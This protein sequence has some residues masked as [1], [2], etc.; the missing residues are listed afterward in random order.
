MDCPGEGQR[1]RLDGALWVFGKDRSGGSGHATWRSV[2]GIQWE[3]VETGA[4]VFS[5]A[6][7]VVHQDSLFLY[8]QSGEQ[9][10]PMRRYGAARA[11]VDSLQGIRYVLDQSPGTMPD[12]APLDPKTYVISEPLPPG[13]YWLHV[14][15][16]DSLGHL[17]AVAHRA[18]HVLPV[19][20]PTVAIDGSTSFS[21]IP[22][23]AMNISLVNQER[24]PEATDY[25]GLHSAP[26]GDADTAVSNSD[27]TLPCVAEGTYWLVAQSVDMYGI[28]SERFEQ[29][30]S[31][32]PPATLS[33]PTMHFAGLDPETEDKVH[34]YAP[35]GRDIWMSPARLGGDIA[36]TV[37]DHR[38]GLPT[39]FSEAT[40][41]PATGFPLPL[42]EVGRHY[43]HAITLDNCNLPSEES[44]LSALVVQGP[45]P[46]VE[47]FRSDT[48]GSIILNLGWNELRTGVMDVRYVIDQEPDTDPAMDS[49]AFFGSEIEI[50]APD[51]VSWQFYVHLAEVEGPQHLSR[52]SH[53]LMRNDESGLVIVQ[54]PYYTEGVPYYYVD[55]PGAEHVS[56]NPAFMR[57]LPLVDGAKRNVLVSATS[58]GRHKIQVASAPDGPV[59]LEFPLG[60]IGAA[61]GWLPATG[62]TATAY[63]DH[64]PPALLVE[65]PSGESAVSDPL[66]FRLSAPDAD[67]LFMPPRVFSLVQISFKD[68]FGQAY[69]ANGIRCL[70]H[71]LHGCRAIRDGAPAGPHVRSQYT[72][73]VVYRLRRIRLGWQLHARFQQRLAGLC[74]GGSRSDDCSAGRIE[75]QQGSC[76][77]HPPAQQ[78]HCEHAGCK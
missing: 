49:T 25:F 26:G 9:P 46:Y 35:E 38:Y 51:E 40:P 59:Y 67:D 45:P 42:L 77:L 54:G 20:E 34:V 30:I 63:I 75:V 68:T 31:V 50:P 6:D 5:Q 4:G 62:P 24:L 12:S 60:S 19:A 73:H 18:I 64:T 58:L 47:V 39:D 27:F 2:D 56:I 36:Y 10:R 28:A 3:P 61:S 72:S 52:T 55:T 21:Q 76:K 29:E 78:T 44:V 17:G 13:D 8:T 65:G 66:V 32:G 37:I 70:D 16:V 53:F 7:A 23:N 69:G 74:V 71:H 22:G 14:G 57:V 41:V 11:G 48:T 15:M 1:C 43:F 33:G